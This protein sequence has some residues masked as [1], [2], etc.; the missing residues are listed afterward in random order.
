ML[1]LLKTPFSCKGSYMAIVQYDE[2]LSYHGIIANPNGNGIYLKSV[3]GKSRHCNAIWKIVPKVANCI[4]PFKIEYAYHELKLLGNDFEI[5]M[6]YIDDSKLILQATGKNLSIDFDSLPESMYDY[7][8]K[9]KDDMNDEYYVVNSYKSQTKYFVSSSARIKLNQKYSD[10]MQGASKSVL[11]INDNDFFVVIQ[12]IATNLDK[13]QKIFKEYDYYAKKAKESFLEYTNKF[14]KPLNEYEDAYIDALYTTWSATVKRQGL[15]KRDVTYM[16]NTFFPGVWSWDHCFNSLG[17][18]E[19]DQNLSY[20]N[21]MVVYDFQDSF[22]QLPGSMNDSNVHWN[23]S[24]PPIQGWIFGILMK[25]G[26]LNKEQCCK[27]YEKLLKQQ[28]YWFEYHDCNNDGVPEY[29]HGND[30]GFDN[31]TVFKESMVMDSPDLLAYLI[32]G[33]ETLEQIGKKLGKNIEYITEQKN[34]S[35]H[36]FREYF[37]VEDQIIA[38]NPISG[39][40]VD[41]DSIL[42]YLSLCIAQYLPSNIVKKM[43]QNLKENFVTI[44]GLST[45][46]VSSSMYE[47]DG[48]W[49]GPIWAPE[50]VLLVEALE[51]IGETEFVKDLLYNFLNTIKNS[52]F[53]ENYNAKTGKGLRDP[54]HTWTSSSFLYLEEKYHKKYI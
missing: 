6:C 43:V 45:E 26:V 13:R 37:I 53:Y 51:D 18:L 22:G 14:P 10:D 15:L 28:E 48:Y 4:V 25:N 20:D 19:G 11:T 50:M 40:I 5:K 9:L 32:K 42:P 54:A 47:E 33:W 34:K 16:S 27:I 49:R 38:R 39:E 12:D 21:M 44:N 29:H 41:N 24:K 8:F 31:S 46:Q 1:D 30:S 17:L 52:G 35:I 2:K 36:K 23:F 7:S 3:K